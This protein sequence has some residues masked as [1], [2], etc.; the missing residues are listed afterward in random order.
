[1]NCI[2]GHKK[3]NH[4]HRYETIKECGYP[5]CQ[6]VKF[7]EANIKATWDKEK[8]L[9]KPDKPGVWCWHE[10]KDDDGYCGAETFHHAA[11]EKS[12]RPRA[13]WKFLCPVPA[14]P[15]SPATD[16]EIAAAAREYARKVFLPTP[17]GCTAEE[18][19]YLRNKIVDLVNR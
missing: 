5:S 11:P 8:W 12:T 2:C 9:D 3:E 16:A 7:L 6:C 15:P 10:W 19:R 1:M 4:W 17:G 14:P 18:R 13:K